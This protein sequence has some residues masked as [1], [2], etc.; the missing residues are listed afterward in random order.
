MK[1]GILNSEHCEK[2]N[3]CKHITS[4]NYQWCYMFKNEPETLPCGQHD[5]FALERAITGH[6]I[7]KNPALILA[8][9]PH[10]QN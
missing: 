1:N 7:K 5:K 3:G 6:L 2:C 9:L 8:F 10:I 4:S